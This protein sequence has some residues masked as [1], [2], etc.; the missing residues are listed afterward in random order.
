MY[1]TN[2]HLNCL[3]VAH[4]F[5]LLPCVFPPAVSELV[6]W[7]M[8]FL[9]HSCKQAQPMTRNA[10]ARWRRSSLFPTGIDSSVAM[11]SVVNRG[12]NTWFISIN[13]STK[14]SINQSINQSIFKIWSCS[15]DIQVCQHT[16]YCPM[17]SYRYTNKKWLISMQIASILK[18]E[19]YSS[20][21]TYCKYSETSIKRP[22]VERTPC[23][24]RTV[25]KVPN[26]ILVNPLN[27]SFILPTA[28]LQSEINNRILSCFTSMFYDENRKM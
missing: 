21:F 5:L 28:W 16:Y 1:K 9:S 25:P 14:Q 10:F 2:Y 13:Q 20:S 4:S 17:T 18:R 7:P 6:H 26:W 11:L 8:L 23:I 3:N 19:L 12:S 24:K 22:C 27:K 15:Y